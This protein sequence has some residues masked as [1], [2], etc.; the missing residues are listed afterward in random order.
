MDDG[1]CRHGA[2]DRSPVLNQFQLRIM[3][4]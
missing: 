3:A 2:P 4:L 1:Q